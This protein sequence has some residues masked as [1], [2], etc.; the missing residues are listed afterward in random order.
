MPYVMDLAQGQNKISAQYTPANTISTMIFN[1]WLHVCI[2]WEVLK[3]A[4]P[5]RHTSPHKLE[6][7]MIESRHQYFKPPRLLHVQLMLRNTE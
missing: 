1:L 4:K 2:T 6:S 5:R 7:L 3:I